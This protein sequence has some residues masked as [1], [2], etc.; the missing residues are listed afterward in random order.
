MRGPWSDVRW[1]VQEIGL[2]RKADIYRGNA[3]TSQQ[4]FSNVVSLF[5]SG[6]E[7]LRK[8]FQRAKEF[9]NHPDL[10]G[11]VEALGARSLVSCRQ[12]GREIRGW[13]HDG[14]SVFHRRAHVDIDWIRSLGITGY[15]VCHPVAGI[16][17]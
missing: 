9:R 8:L 15:F 13:D 10:L 11:E 17:Y 3:S 5:T 4:K 6:N 1:I 2:A 12:L 14:T 16:R 7:D